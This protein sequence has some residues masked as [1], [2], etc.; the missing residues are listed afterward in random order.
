MLVLLVLIPVAEHM[1]GAEPKPACEFSH[2][3]SV[4]TPYC[5]NMGTLLQCNQE[6][7]FGAAAGTRFAHYKQAAAHKQSKVQA[8]QSASAKSHG[9]P[10]TSSEL[11]SVQPRQ[12]TSLYTPYA[13]CLLGNTEV[14]WR[15]HVADTMCSAMCVRQKVNT[16]FQAAGRPRSGTQPLVTHKKCSG[17]ACKRNIRVGIECQCR[18][19]KVQCVATQM[20]THLVWS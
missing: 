19:I 10:H 4:V 17:C 9:L 5:H 14:V 20:L 11:N 18:N 1:Q 2:C 15:L 13:A 6:K 8:S 3:M 7:N 12:L 16:Y